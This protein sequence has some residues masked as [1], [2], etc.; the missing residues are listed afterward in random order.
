[1][2]N[3]PAAKPAVMFVCVK[4]GGKSQM[5]AALARLHAGDTLEIHSAGTAPT[6]G[7]TINALSAESVAELG[8]S[9]AGE[10]PKPMD[11]ALTARMDRIVLVGT[12]AQLDPALELRHPAVVW[13]IDEP[14][15]RGIDGEERMR[16]V[17]D[18]IDRRVLALIEELTQ[19]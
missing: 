7:G 6:P 19:H 1:M 9:M 3:T 8:A 14:S 2:N 15:L 16:L 13:E 11:P 10:I 5:A 17:R 12:E 18:D 4:N